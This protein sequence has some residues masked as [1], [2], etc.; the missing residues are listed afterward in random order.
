MSACRRSR[1]RRI[2]SRRNESLAA[3][4]AAAVPRQPTLTEIV[5]QPRAPSGAGG[6]RLLRLDRAG[7]VGRAD[8]DLVAPGVAAQS[9][10]HWTQVASE[11]GADSRASRQTPSMATSTLRDA[12]VRGPGDAGDRAPGPRRDAAA[13]R[14]DPRLGQ[15]RA[16]LGPAEGDPVAVERLER[17]QLQL[18]EPLRRRHV[19]E[20]PGDDEAGRVAVDPAAAARRS[21]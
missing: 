20:Q 16:V 9:V 8:H 18:L 14:V 4:A 2:P 1:S 15:D 10:T 21:S 3:V 12:A 6:E 19:A 13:R 11:I 7:P 17:R 5:C